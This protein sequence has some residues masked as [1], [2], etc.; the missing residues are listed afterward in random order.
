MSVTPPSRS[1]TQS[2]RTIVAAAAVW[3]C[4]LAGAAPSISPRSMPAIA[5]LDERFLSYNVEMAEVVGGTFWKPYA[6][7]DKSAR[8]SGEPASARADSP[9]PAFQIGQGSSMFEARPPVDLTESWLRKLADALGAGLRTRER[10]VGQFRLFRRPRWTLTVEAAEGISKRPDAG[11]VEGRCG[12]RTR[13]RCED[14]HLF[15]H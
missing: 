14:R 12:F 8:A 4:G 13:S 3:A 1:L 15:R 6:A 11:G 10:H 2:A 9:A 7:L 5:S